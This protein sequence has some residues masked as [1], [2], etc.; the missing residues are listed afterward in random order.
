MTVQATTARDTNQFLM[1][2][3]LLYYSTVVVMFWLKFSDCAN[4][5]SQPPV[6]RPRT[7]IKWLINTGN[8][9]GRWS[10]PKWT[11]RTNGT[12]A[13][14]GGN[15]TQCRTAVLTPN[16]VTRM[17]M[18]RGGTAAVLVMP[19]GDGGNRCCGNGTPYRYSLGV[20]ELKHGTN[21]LYPAI[22]PFPDWKLFE[23]RGGRRM[24]PEPDSSDRPQISANPSNTEPADN[25]T[26]INDAP[27]RGVAT[28][29]GNG[30]GAD[31]HRQPRIVNV[32]DAYLDDR[33][34]LLWVLDTGG[35]GEDAC[36]G[37]AMSPDSDRSSETDDQSPPKFFAVDVH[38]NKV[39]TRIL[40]SPLHTDLTFVFTL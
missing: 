26:E 11:R 15:H 38:T 39:Y 18:I 23:V 22:Q 33:G 7:R 37:N 30:T 20:V 28:G 4:T 21:N 24:S 12:A 27:L 29:S 19:T 34:R 32:V 2:F 5:T 35:V 13:V 9:A 40:L 10:P 16:T 36:Y 14:D 6:D 31:D 8:V 1:L 25:D 17:Q 3:A